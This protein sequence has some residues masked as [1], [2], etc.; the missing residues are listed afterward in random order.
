MSTVPILHPDWPAPRC[1]RAGCTTRIGGVSAA[2]FSGLNLG[3]SS[4]DDIA[5]VLENRRRALAALQAPAEPSWLRQVHGTQ[6]VR[7]PF[8]E[9]TPAAD[10]S[11]TTQA[12][13]VCAVQAAD[14]LPVLFC[15]DGGSVVAAA[16]AGW[17]G[18][19][20]GILEA[21]VAALPTEPRTLMAWL[22]PAIGPE[23]FE[24]GAEVCAAFVAVDPSS[25]QYFRKADFRAASDQ[26]AVDKYF[27]DLFALAR[28]RLALAGVTR[29]YGGGIST[30]ADAERFYS[31]RRDGVTG[32]MAAMIW[33][34]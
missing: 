33:L 29:V 13:V 5:H 30:H 27:A 24:V 2:P 10:A 31:F 28:G 21:T 15:D 26:A 9:T 19:A 8:A 4:G 18:L 3:R 14:C 25:A 23:A 11:F 7:A 16:H 22:G 20:A 32:R 6:V 1:V 12:G 34:Q 17:R